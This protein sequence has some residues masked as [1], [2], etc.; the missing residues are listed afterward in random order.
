[1]GFRAWE[2]FEGVGFGV[3]GFWGLGVLGLWG[4][5]FVG[6]GVLNGLGFV[7]CWRAHKGLRAQEFVE[8]RV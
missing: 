5:R 7:G 6:C 3:L 2:E 8:F 4:C 1:M